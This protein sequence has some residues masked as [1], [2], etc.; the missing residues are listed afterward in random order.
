MFN[1]W[2]CILTSSSPQE[3]ILICSCSLRMPT[4]SMILEVSVRFEFA[5]G[6]AGIFSSVGAV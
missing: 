1:L 6:S 5:P 2:G 4:I 3:G